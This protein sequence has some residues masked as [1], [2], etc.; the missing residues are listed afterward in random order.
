ME[1]SS[2]EVVINLLI[3]AIQRHSTLFNMFNKNVLYYPL[4]AA[5]ANAKTG[6]EVAPQIMAIEYPTRLVG[7]INHKS[8]RQTPINQHQNNAR[9]CWITFYELFKSCAEFIKVC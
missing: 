7:N 8:V 6:K 9:F 1:K 2:V 5:V 4:H 3:A